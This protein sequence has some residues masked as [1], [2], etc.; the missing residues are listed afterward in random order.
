MMPT[1]E[2][3]LEILSMNIFLWRTLSDITGKRIMDK[4]HIPQGLISAH[5][6]AHSFHLRSILVNYLFV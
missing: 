4:Y 2:Y 3:C 1:A 6:L 5:L